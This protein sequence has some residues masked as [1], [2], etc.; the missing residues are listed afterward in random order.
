MNGFSYLL[1]LSPIIAGV[2]FFA[3]MRSLTSS[4]R[5]MIHDAVQEA[6]ALP[7]RCEP[8]SSKTHAENV[9]AYVRDAM[10]VKGIMPDSTDMLAR[11][12]SELGL[13]GTENIPLIDK[14]TAPS[15]IELLVGD[16]HK[17]KTQICRF[18]CQS[19]FLLLY[20]LNNRLKVLCI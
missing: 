7:T 6:P 16:I 12:Y 1:N 10:I 18:E 8:E 4:R 17:A 9:L 3:I 2:M 19:G 5:V 14:Y 20:L 13:L 11:A 15:Q